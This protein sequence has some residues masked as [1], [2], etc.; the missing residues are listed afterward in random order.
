MGEKK[1]K[2]HALLCLS[3]TCEALIAVLCLGPDSLINKPMLLLNSPAEAMPKCTGLGKTQQVSTLLNLN[4]NN[5]TD[6]FC[7]RD[8]QARKDCSLNH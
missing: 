8:N 3:S 6:A 7:R 2:S 4:N 5:D 1:K